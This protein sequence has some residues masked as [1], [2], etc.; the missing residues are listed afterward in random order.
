MLFY[1][2]LLILDDNAISNIENQKIVRYVWSREGKWETCR[3]IA[4]KR[5]TWEPVF[6]GVQNGVVLMD[7]DYVLS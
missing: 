3:C 5:R 6:L 1:I 2:C 7:G 4:D